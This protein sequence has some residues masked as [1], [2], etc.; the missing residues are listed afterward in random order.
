MKISAE[1]REKAFKIIWRKEGKFSLEEIVAVL[2]LYYT[3]QDI[4]ELIERN[5]QSE[6][7]RLITSFKDVSGVR[8]TFSPEGKNEFVNIEISSSLDDLDAIRKQLK[9]RIKGY[10]K[11]LSKVTRRQNEVYQMTLFDAV[12]EDEQQV[13]PKAGVK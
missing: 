11:S 7:Y 5:L 10:K 1:A 4:D 6:A 9:K 12:T 3:Q 13:L 8:Q 2:R